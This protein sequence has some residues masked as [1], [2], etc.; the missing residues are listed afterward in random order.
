MEDIVITRPII[1]I[2][3]M[4]VCAVKT[5]TDEQILAYCNEK[6]PAGTTNGWTT[7]IKNDTDA[8]LNPV[9]C[10]EHQDRVHYLISC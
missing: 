9:T 10:E 6:N 5:A 2:Y 4:Q 1:G 3:Y 7:V 8:N